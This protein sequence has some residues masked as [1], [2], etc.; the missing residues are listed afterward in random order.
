[1]YIAAYVYYHVLLYIYGVRRTRSCS[2]KHQVFYNTFALKLTY[3]II[4]TDINVILLYFA[5]FYIIKS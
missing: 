5:D 2:F 3:K 1:M 4:T